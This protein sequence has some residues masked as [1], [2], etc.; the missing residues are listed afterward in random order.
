MLG[1]I[2]L[3]DKTYEDIIAEAIERIP[4]HTSEWTNF[5]QSDPGITI[6]QNLSA[7]TML[8]QNYIN[9][10][11]DVLR[12]RLLGLLGFEAGEYKS[13]RVL[14][15]EEKNRE[16][17][18]PAGK[19]LMAGGLCFESE[20]EINLTPWGINAVYIEQDG[21]FKD[22]TYLL[23]KDARAGAYVFGAPAKN[24]SSFYCIF[25]ELPQEELVIHV[26]ASDDEKRKRNPFKGD[27]LSFAKLSWQC[28]TGCKSRGGWENIEFTD[29]TRGFLLDGIIRL[30]LPDTVVPVEFAEVPVKGLAIRCVL[31]EGCYDIPPRISSVS[32]NFFEAVQ[33]DT[34]AKS[35]VFHGPKNVELR[36]AITDY[37]YFNVYGRE[38]KKG[39]YRAYKP[40]SPHM[41]D[42][43]GR[44]YTLTQQPDGSLRFSFDKKRFGYAP[45]Q[46]FASVRIVCY[47]ED[48]IHHFRLGRVEGYENQVINLEQIERVLPDEFCLLAEA[49]DVKGETG[50]YFVE[51][52]LTNPDY[53]CYSVLSEQGAIKIGEPGL[54]DDCSLFLADCVVTEGEG[55]NVIAGNKFDTGE[56]FPVFVNPAAGF[57]GA[58]AETSEQLRL[59][60]L[61]D[62]KS[63]SAAVTPG[64]YENLALNTPGFCIHKVKAV[65][66]S[67]KNI[68]RVAVKPY[69]SEEEPL[70]KLSPGHIEHI[71]R[72]LDKRR[73]I[74]T[75]VE[76]C[77]PVYVPID[78]K[79]SVYVK[80][81]FENADAEIKQFIRQALDGVSTDIPF[82]SAVSY[83]QLFKALEELPCIDSLHELGISTRAGRYTKSVGTDIQLG[84]DALYYAQQI[85][86]EIITKH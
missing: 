19:K 24:N 68:M 64:D 63:T 33:K 43:N 85:S 15:S 42:E 83:N 71:S 55:G 70:P 23:G 62:I 75:V 11:S 79:A 40:L 59:R 3:A 7:F 74:T 18:I 5:N 45:G 56:S 27:S 14:L 8:Q 48:I 47:S 82:G 30:R 86:I 51:P 39:A 60:L 72:W 73:M 38:E 49:S 78:V 61:N 54:M 57:G 16:A 20:K 21:A 2:N 58:S 52:G 32:V 36:H 22:I 10:F 84:D 26:Q 1:N 50:Y 31:N 17:H 29:E 67:A 44:Y 41:E 69:S 80:S 46:G 76:L 13:A 53:L 65:F 12:S 4:L 37:G 34:K 25:S 66:D 28:Y 6:L 77:Q 9:Q 35:F 81:Y